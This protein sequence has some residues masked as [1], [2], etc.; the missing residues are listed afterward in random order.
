MIAT[1]SVDELAKWIDEAY[2][3]SWPR[4]ASYQLARY[5]D[6][7]CF[8]QWEATGEEL[9][10][11]GHTIKIEWSHYYSLDEV[12]KAYR[13]DEDGAREWL[14]ANGDVIFYRAINSDRESVLFRETVEG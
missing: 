5:Y 7:L 4:E 8:E 2:D 12:C 14:E 3:T 6:N 1:I 13:L 9:R 11:N 10:V